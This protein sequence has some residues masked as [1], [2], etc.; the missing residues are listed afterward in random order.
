MSR[1]PRGG[2]LA[3]L[4]A[5]SRCRGHARS[6]SSP[7]GSA[8]SVREDRA[9]DPTARAFAACALFA[10]AGPS[11]PSRRRNR[12]PDATDGVSGPRFRF[13]ARLA[14][15]ASESFAH[16]RAGTQTS[17]GE[18]RRRQRND[19]CRR[20][21]ARRI[22]SPSRLAAPQPRRR[23]SWS[24]RA[25]EVDT[26]FFLDPNDIQATT[27]AEADR[28]VDNDYTTDKHSKC[29]LQPTGR[30]PRNCGRSATRLRI[31]SPTAAPG[32]SGV[33]ESRETDLLDP[34][35]KRPRGL[36]RRTPGQT[37]VERQSDTTCPSAGTL[38]ARTCPSPAP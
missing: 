14:G 5:A 20:T 30:G 29:Q 21:R 36:R 3:F 23:L 16:D 26:R 25:T 28:S 6:P 31:A 27:T 19:Y 18:G 22:S 38:P 35:T 34:H 9:R 13:Q 7:T 2:L 12:E 1:G 11:G 24:G 32:S 33:T 10:R 15:R 4:L 37:D 8:G 17:L